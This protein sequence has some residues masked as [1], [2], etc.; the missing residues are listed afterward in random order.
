LE[1]KGYSAG[2]Y[3]IFPMYRYVPERNDGFSRAINQAAG[4]GRWMAT[5]RGSHAS[6]LRKCPS[7]SGQTPAALKTGSR[8]AGNQGSGSNSKDHGSLKR[9]T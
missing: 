1:R 4:L 2:I 7:L 8:G 6:S 3:A 9:L 5:G